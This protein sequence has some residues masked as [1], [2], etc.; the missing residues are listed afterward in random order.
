MMYSSAPPPDAARALAPVELSLMELVQLVWR[1]RYLVIAI[2]AAV[3][4]IATIAAF[5]VQKRYTATIVV[6]PVSNSGAAGSIGGLSSL[7]SQFGGL[8]SLAGVSLADDGGKAEAIAVL[9]SDALT[10]RY[11]RENELLLILFK[12]AWDADARRWKTTDPEKTPTPWK[13]MQYFKKKV[14]QIVEDKKTGMLN[15]SITWTDPEVAAKWAN[16]LVKLTNDYLR[17]K[18][19]DESERHIKY[20]HEQAEKTEMVQLRSAIFS[21]MESEIKRGMLARGTDEYAL[22]VIDPAVPPE[23]A[24]F[25]QRKLWIAGGFLLGGVLSVLFVLARRIFEGEQINESAA[26]G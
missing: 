17:A 18:A 26:A 8:A 10:Q 16:E 24:A 22:K 14:R 5:V 4:A 11:I 6:A 3:A 12:K 25:P 9:K 19:I 2:T 13:G 15:L 1:S 21:V 23:L 20:L 7:I